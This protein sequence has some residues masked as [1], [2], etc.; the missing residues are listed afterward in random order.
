MP[1]SA[2]AILLAASTIVPIAST[3]SITPAAKQELRL[4]MGAILRGQGGEA[5]SA[6]QSISPTELS[7]EDR[8]F[9]SCALSRLNPDNTMQMTSDILHENTFTHDILNLYRTYWRTSALNANSRPT[10]EKALT[11]GLANLL[12]RPLNNI[13][14]AE[15]LIAARLTAY[16][17]FS[18]EGRTG[19]L[20][21]LMIWSRNTQKIEQV[22]LPEGSN[23][24][25]VNYLDGFISRGWS[26]YL[27]CNYTGTGGWTTS[28]GLFVI[29]PSYDSLTDEKFRVNLLAHESQ[30]YS[31]KKRFG[32]MPLWRLE[33][34]A[35]LA[36][37]A[38]ATTTRNRV[39]DAFV[40]NQSDDPGDPHS[41]ANKKVLKILMTRLGLTSAA[42]LYTVSVDRLHQTAINALRADS[43]ALDTARRDSV[44]P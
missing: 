23:A 40:A 10:A 24:T 34:R 21:D 1:A 25:H 44:P 29:V 26:S 38:Y 19:V 33:Y 32:D 5:Q 22:P 3:I 27:T 37:V 11:N 9:R 17:L 36:E 16:G 39:L 4:A 35:K 13:A 14:E 2:N 18:Q 41:Y 28:D 30:H 8:Y 31:D 15:P 42:S 6:L 20:H 43:V 12:S 7:S